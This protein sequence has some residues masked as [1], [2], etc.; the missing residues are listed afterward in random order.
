MTKIDCEKTAPLKL[1]VW[2]AVLLCFLVVPATSQAGFDPR[3]VPALAV[4]AGTGVSRG[5]EDNIISRLWN[6]DACVDSALDFGQALGD[7]MSDY[8]VCDGWRIRQLTNYTGGHTALLL[9][10]PNGESYYV[11]NYFGRPEIQPM[12]KV[13]E[14]TYTMEPVPGL[15]NTSTGG[16]LFGVLPWEARDYGLDIT[17]GGTSSAPEPTALLADGVPEDD[18]TLKSSVFESV[19]PN[20]KFGPQGYGT[21]RYVRGDTPFSYMVVFENLATATAPAQQVAVL[22]QIPASLNFA[23]LQLGPIT[24][25][26]QTVTPPA[27]VMDYS[28]FIDQRPENNVVVAI[29]VMADSEDRMI[30]WEFTS[31]DPDTIDPECEDCGFSEMVPLEY[32]D[33]TRGFL[34][35]NMASPQGQGHVT[36]IMAPV[37]SIANGDV[38]PN[39]AE[40]YFDT[41][42]PIITA[43]WLNTIDIQ[44]PESHVL[45][46]DPIQ[47]TPSFTVQWTG[48][49]GG[50][51][52]GGYDIF[53]S[54]DGGITYT[55]WL[56]NT[57]ETAAL[58]TFGKSG[59]TYKFYSVARD[60]V[61]NREGVPDTSDAETTVVVSAEEICGDNIDNDFDGLVDEDCEPACA[62]DGDLDGDCAVDASDRI[63]FIGAFRSCEGDANYLPEADYDGDGCITHG[64]YRE[65]F[66]Y[67]RAY[68]SS[69]TPS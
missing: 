7:T 39:Q 62:I 19:D 20:A 1:F 2:M 48:S 36:F 41:N 31:L 8:D 59:T 49:D 16:D 55:Q 15:G 3:D 52:V 13:T 63:I 4:V 40:I 58:F 42:D 54:S 24:I 43:P 28:T 46:L 66:K 18:A 51:G 9:E 5:W 47:S 25:A 21:Q 68:L 60:N 27:G 56:N 65:W 17:V 57:S 14:H 53:V 35:P 67:Y 33:P 44:A 29:R 12:T 23:T 11:D 50:S 22:D 32:T 37:S 26:D 64:D 69:Q 45:P 10:S 34:P 61:G 30:I 6:G 38:V